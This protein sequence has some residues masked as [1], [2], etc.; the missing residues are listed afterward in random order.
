MTDPQPNQEKAEKR[1]VAAKIY[2]KTVSTS[3]S[4]WIQNSR[5][6]SKFQPLHHQVHR[7]HLQRPGASV[8]CRSSCSQ[9]LSVSHPSTLKNKPIFGNHHLAC[10]ASPE[11]MNHGRDGSCR[12]SSSKKKHSTQHTVSA[13]CIA[14]N[15]PH[16]GF[17]NQPHNGFSPAAVP[18]A[19]KQCVWRRR[20]HETRRCH[21]SNVE[22]QLC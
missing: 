20:M 9:I 1:R 2:Q 5:S 6:T 17:A 21:A 7:V 8:L 19:A 3:E 16:N 12:S 13:G 18:A 10:K 4:S 14:N 22:P 15:Q 11:S